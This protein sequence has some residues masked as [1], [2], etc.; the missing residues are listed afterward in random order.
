V[1]WQ[2]Y[3]TEPTVCYILAVTKSKILGGELPVFGLVNTG[4]W[5]ISLQLLKRPGP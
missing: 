5:P 1:T 4:I 3:R 2:A